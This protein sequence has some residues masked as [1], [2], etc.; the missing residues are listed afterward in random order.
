[1]GSNLLLVVSEDFR[2]IS[3]RHI[4]EVDSQ[5]GFTAVRKLPGSSD[6]FMALKVLEIGPR[7]ETLLCVFDLAGHF[8]TDPPFISVSAE[9][10][11]EG[12]EFL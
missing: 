12:L 2:D 1:M 10:K 4:G 11:F 6:T 8:L 7:T 3:V 5:F 9:F